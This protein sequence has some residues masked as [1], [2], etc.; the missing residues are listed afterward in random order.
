MVSSYT[1]QFQTASIAALLG[2]IA[3]TTPGVVKM[4]TP[5]T[6]EMTIADASSGPSRRSSEVGGGSGVTRQS[7]LGDQNPRD[8]ILPDALPLRRSVFREQLHLG[9]DEVA[10]A[11]HFLAR[12]VGAG[13]A[14]L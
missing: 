4:P 5:M 10:V 14:G 11:E 12:L 2:N 6:F 9:V 8:R 13:V 3:A 7:S 1:E